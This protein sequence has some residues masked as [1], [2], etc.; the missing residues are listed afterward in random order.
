[1]NNQKKSF[2]SFLKEVRVYLG[3]R[4]VMLLAVAALSAL[5]A[6][7]LSAFFLPPFVIVSILILLCFASVSMLL[8][9]RDVARSGIEDKIRNIELGAVV[10]NIRDGVVVYDPNFRIISMNRAA[11]ELFGVSA[12]ETVGT[13]ITPELVNNTH[14]RIL[15][16]VIFPSLAP[17]I[18]TLSGDWPQV[19]DLAFEEPRLELHTVL[20][21]IVGNDGGVVGFLKLITDTTRE[22]AILESKGEFITVAAHQLRTPLTAL[23]WIFETIQKTVKEGGAVD[24]SVV[25]NINEG[26]QLTQRSLKII[27]DLLDAA[28][29]EEG[30]FG[31]H[32]QDVVL[33]ELVKTIS[34]EASIIAREKE[35]AV[36]F[37][38][39]AEHNVVWADPERLGIAVSNF[40]DNAIKY[41]TRGGSVDVSVDPSPDGA[42]L[43][44]RIAD[45]GIGIMKEDIAKLSQKFYRAENATQLEPNGSGLGVYIAKNIIERH[46]GAM[47]VTSEP[48]R[49][50]IFSFT[51]PIKNI[52]TEVRKQ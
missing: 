13:F 50:T 35:V 40:I 28:T 23:G 16:Q 47:S 30:R 3:P 1:M 27:N 17:S 19:V 10:E 12:K 14:L 51:V 45:T 52:R 26:W 33:A 44:V 41:N 31:F 15:T 5:L 49:G 46:G 32:F 39:R 36:R 18:S 9:Y 24:P 4:N 11:E 21:R 38:A 2:F 7:L 25:S 20:N 34:N 48:E 6:V 22:K 29:I 37:S 43:V 42:S 8:G